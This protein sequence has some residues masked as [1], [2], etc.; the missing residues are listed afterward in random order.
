[1]ISTD[2]ARRQRRL[3]VNHRNYGGDPRES[4]RL[5]PLF[6]RWA[7]VRSNAAALRECGIDYGHGSAWLAGRTVLAKRHQE[8]VR[9]VLEFAGIA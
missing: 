3:P 8:T 9:G 2:T 4:D 5:R 1:M 6:L 7:G